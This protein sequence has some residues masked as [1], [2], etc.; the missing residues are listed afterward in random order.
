MPLGL[1]PAIILEPSDV[2]IF[3]A[4]K[5]TSPRA[6]ILPLT[7]ILFVDSLPGCKYVLPLA[8]YLTRPVPSIEKFLPLIS[9]ARGLSPS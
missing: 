9:V 8:P 5:S 6:A 2:F 1:T 7:S 3:A 4:L